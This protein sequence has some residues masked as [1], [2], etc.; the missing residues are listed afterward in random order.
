MIQ[1]YRTKIEEK[2]KMTE[3]T[4]QMQ[5]WASKMRMHSSKNA[6]IAKKISIMV[7]RVN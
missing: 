5:I 1:V 2:K 6:I 4:M 3:M 7:M